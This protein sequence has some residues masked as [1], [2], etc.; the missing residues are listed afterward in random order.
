MTRVLAID[1][2]EKRVGIA[3]SDPLG[4]TAQAQ[5]FIPNDS[6]LMPLIEAISNEKNI[7]KIIVGLPTNRYKKDTQQT[8]KVRAFVDIL[9]K[10]IQIPIEYVDE[11]FSTKA[12]ERH[13][14]TADVSR[15][16]RKTSI[17]SLSAA[18]FLQGYLDKQI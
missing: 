12:M 6:K 16:K 3:L 9:K 15:K 17:D 4:V 10:Q 13:L 7:S 11:R 18:F 8:T 5:P 2:G 14:V 1:Y